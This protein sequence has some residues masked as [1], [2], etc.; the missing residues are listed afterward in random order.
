MKK[1]IEMVVF[2]L[3]IVMGMVGCKQLNT[4]DTLVSIDVN[5]NYPEKNL[6]LQDFMDVEYIPLESTDKFVTQGDIMAIGRKLILAKNYINDGNIYVFDRR[7][8]KGLR[9]INRLGQ[10]NEEYAFINGIVLDEKNEEMFVNCTPMKKILVYDLF[11][12]FKR[13][14]KHTEGS[15]YL[16]VFNYNKDNLLRYD[17]SIY[18]KDGEKK[19]TEFYHAVISKQDGHVVQGIS[20][21]FSIVKTPFVRNGNAMVA[22]SIRSITPCKNNWLLTE[23]SSDTV[24]CYSNDNKMEPFLVKKSSGDP[25]VFLTVGVVCDQY[26]FIQTVKKIFNFEKGRGFPKNDLMYD[27]KEKAVF[28]TSVLNADYIN[29]QK[30]DMTSHVGNDEIATFQNL[31]AYELIEAYKK[32]EL[33]GELKEIA[34]KLNEESNPVVMLVKYKSKPPVKYVLQN[35]KISPDS[36]RFVQIRLRVGT[37]NIKLYQFGTD[38]F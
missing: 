20:I 25:D 9:I 26:Y 13:S 10:G 27:K 17:M 5:V 35:R 33:K 3:S 19:G 4:T 7:T 1:E 24:Y 16:E 12:N 15:E 34:T 31:E 23:T 8:G 21:P 38:L 28:K 36:V 2:F 14:F 11:G 29:R 30:V 22:T 6:I 32:N 37:N 18:Y